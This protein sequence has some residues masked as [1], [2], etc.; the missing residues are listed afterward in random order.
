MVS[1][2]GDHDDFSKDRLNFYI[3][4]NNIHFTL[5]PMLSGVLWLANHYLM[6]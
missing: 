2:L 6:V 1:E 4:Y 5:S 3:T